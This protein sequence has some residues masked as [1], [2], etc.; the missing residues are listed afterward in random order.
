M[1]K[2]KAFL[3]KI[4]DEPPPCVQIGDPELFFPK[5]Y[6]DEHQFQVRQAKS[7]CR[8]CKL[9]ADCLEFALDTGDQHGV[10]AG[11][12]PAQREIIRRRRNEQELRNTAAAAREFET[13][14]KRAAA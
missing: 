2:H 14:R 10:L 13:E 1:S 11:T 6:G 5:S 4:T 9:I 3:Q 8:K 12:D 7:I